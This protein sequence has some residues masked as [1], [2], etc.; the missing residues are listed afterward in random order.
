MQLTAQQLRA[1]GVT[2]KYHPK[3]FTSSAPRSSSYCIPAPRLSV[4]P[5]AGSDG[6]SS[7]GND[8]EEL[9]RLKQKF[10]SN[11]NPGSTSSSSPQPQITPDQAASGD[12][13]L[14]SVNP[15]E[16]GRQARRA[17]DDVWTQLSQ[18]A[19]PTKS[20]IIDDMLE[21]GR[22]SDFEA[23]QAAFTTVLVVGAT[24]RVGRILTRKL[25]LR[26]YKVKALVRKKEGRGQEG[27]GVP[28]AVEIVEG[29]VGELRD[30]Q[31]AVRGVN[32]VIYAA[33]AKTTFTAE[34]LRVEE[35]GVMNITK[36]LQDEFIRQ[37]NERQKGKDTSSRPRYYSDKSKKEI[38]DFK[39]SYHQK[40]WDIVFVGNPDDVKQGVDVRELARANRAVAEINEEE[41]LVFEGKLM[42]RGAIAEVGAKLSSKL[43]D[44]EH[45][46]KD[47]EGLTL[48]VR[49][50]A[51][52]YACV[53]E[54]ADGHKYTSRF[55][56]RVGY[57]HVR[58]PY[59][60]FRPEQAGQ[61]PLDPAHI[62]YIGLRYENRRTPA[63]AAARAAR[64]LLDDAATARREQEF[65]LEV[66]WIKALRAGEEPDVVLVSCAGKSH[67][68]FSSEADL[69][70]VVEYKRKGEDNLRLSGLGYTIIRA[71]TLV[72]EPGGYKAL[73]FDQGD[74]ITESISAADVADI[75]LRSL[76]ESEA[77]NKTF[78]VCYEYETEEGLQMYELVARVPDK[79]GDYL[80]SAVNTLQRNT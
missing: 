35:K 32:K 15:Y 60:T 56:T 68:E 9:D 53:L 54:T 17:F 38:A 31:R 20:F 61:P 47:T 2:H 79:S 16:L 19:S 44:G 12:N 77:R 49:G 22:D 28:P 59:N 29:D 1:C 67:T 48:R 18:L 65:Q 26:G 71:G 5:R 63:V 39:S 10:F 11:A 70:K 55:P 30:C 24:G 45:R 33:A 14:N 58:L 69:K 73:V 78:D 8:G 80:K 66:D 23:P 7:S 51:H 40:R 52:Q 34:L 41:N 74:R 25:L 57:L 72:E 4:V 76:H 36:A 43:P 62:S 64:G 42:Q 21:P 37:G 75:C 27:Y 46:T 50:D 13:L 6:P 3:A